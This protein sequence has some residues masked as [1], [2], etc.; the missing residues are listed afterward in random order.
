MQQ[1]KS[2]SEV[3]IRPR[4]TLLWISGGPGTGK[5]ILSSFLIDHLCSRPEFDSVLFYLFDYVSRERCTHLAAACSLTYQLLRSL[6]LGD[7]QLYKDLIE[8]KDASGQNKAKDFFAL[9]SVFCK[10]VNL[11]SRTAIVIDALDVCLDAEAFLGGLKSV[12]YNNGARVI[13]I[14]RRETNIARQLETSPHIPFGAQE[15]QSDIATFINRRIASSSRLSES[16]AA[17]V[18]FQ[19]FGVVLPQFLLERSEGSFQWVKMSL[20]EAETKLTATE[21]VNTIVRTPPGIFAQ[22]SSILGRYVNERDESTVSICRTVLRWLACVPRPLTLEEILEILKLQYT[23]SAS[24][25]KNDE[26]F[27]LSREAVVS[28]C[29]SLVIEV[30]QTLQ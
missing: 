1:F 13:V 10:H 20:D 22:Y 27:P 3:R 9:W 19:K 25:T 7:N 4:E 26:K 28:S 29:G 11:R 21:I 23:G 14:S 17:S 16:Q 5:T 12:S 6:P 24:N 18:F 15:N 2:W 8:R 30:N